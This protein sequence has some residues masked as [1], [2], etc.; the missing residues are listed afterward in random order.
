[1]GTFNNTRMVNGVYDKSRTCTISE[2]EPLT[3]YIFRIAA[4]NSIGTGPFSDPMIVLLSG[5]LLLC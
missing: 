2:L 1:M 3:D 4:V 5:K